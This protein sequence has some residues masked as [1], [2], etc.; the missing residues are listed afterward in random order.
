VYILDSDII[1][2]IYRVQHSHIFQVEASDLALVFP[3]TVDIGDEESFEEVFRTLF[4][5]H[6]LYQRL[7]FTVQHYT[8]V[9]E[10][11]MFQF[12]DLP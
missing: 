9:A 8:T 7:E 1:S 10:Y 5:E 4:T 11:I 12:L 2:L 6:P 3:I